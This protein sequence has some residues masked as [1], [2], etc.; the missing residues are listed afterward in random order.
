MSIRSINEPDSGHLWMVLP[1]SINEPPSV[2]MPDPPGIASIEPTSVAL[3]APSFTLVVT[4]TGFYAG[5]VIVFA[6]QDEPTT[7][8]ADGT[9]STGV[10]M[11]MWLGA[12]TVPCQVRNFN[13]VSN[14]VDFTFTAT[15]GTRST[16]HAHHAHTV[17]P[18]ELEDEIE[19]AEEEG[20]FKPM[21]KAKSAHG[22]SK[23]KK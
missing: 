7:L 3:G 5:S 20:D 19:Q 12:D 11:D 10:N 15:A 4:G 17:D 6:G 1:A 14:T 21:H 22:A 18:D 2:D 16:G 23:R 8:E 9:L 13:V